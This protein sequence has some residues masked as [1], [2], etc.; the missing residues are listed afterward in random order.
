MNNSDSGENPMNH[1]D[2]QPAGV[3]GTPKFG[4]LLLVLILAVL[5]IVAI[6]FGSEAFYS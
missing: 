5:I 4:R 1:P 3:D 2:E 6:T